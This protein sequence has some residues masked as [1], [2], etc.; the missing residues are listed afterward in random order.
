MSPWA[1]RLTCGKLCRPPR[2]SRDPPKGRRPQTLAL[3]DISLDRENP[4]LH[5]LLSETLAAPGVLGLR[6]GQ[7]EAGRPGDE[8]S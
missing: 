2:W 4:F 5:A 8:A 1:W 7:L 3:A 6:P